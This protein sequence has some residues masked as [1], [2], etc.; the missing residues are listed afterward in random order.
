[1]RFK[2]FVC[3]VLLSAALGPYNFLAGENTGITWKGTI[4]TQNG[5]RIVKNTGEPIYGHRDLKLEQ[6]LVLHY[7]ENEDDIF[8]WIAQVELDN[9]NN[10]YLMDTKRY[11]ILSFDNRGKFRFSFGKK[12][13]GPGEFRY[14]M[15]FFVGEK[16]KIYVLDEYVIHILDIKG[17]YI[18]Q[19]KL[20]RVAGDFFMNEK[21]HAILCYISYSENARKKYKVVEYFNPGKNIKKEIVRYF[22][23]EVVKRVQ[24]GKNFTFHLGHKYTP[25][26]Y[27]K[28]SF[29]N[30]VIF[31]HSSEY[32]LMVVDVRGNV[33][34]KIEKK[35]KA[36]PIS[37]EEKKKLYDLYAPY[38]ETK[39]PKGVF[40]EAMQFPPHRPFFNK[41]L[42]D[43]EGR[44]YVAKLD[45]FLTENEENPA[46]LFDVFD[47]GGYFIYQ[48]KLPFQPNLIKNGFLYFIDT[49]SG[50]GAI[51]L[52]RFKILNWPTS[53]ASLHLK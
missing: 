41:I 31:G 38:Y 16:D 4:D 44:I 49:E 6:D 34:L 14:L 20:G 25:H 28:R 17:K 42:V 50:G 3:L 12:G 19:L 52:R 7:G 9:E 24:D 40:K 39:W 22:D 36:S 29:D 45:S 1:M 8:G 48:L 46:F 32:A 23:G 37:N 2:H 43:G 18:N 47:K 5:T 21:N 13:V 11:K 51:K 27:F 53:P 33:F 35:E 26:F 30:R 10:I 15:D